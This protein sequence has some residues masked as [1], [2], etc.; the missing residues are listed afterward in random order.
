MKPPATSSFFGKKRRGG[1]ENRGGMGDAILAAHLSKEIRI[2]QQKERGRWRPPVPPPTGRSYFDKRV[3]PF[4]FGA[5]RVFFFSV[6]HYQSSARRVNRSN[7]PI[8]KGNPETKF[9]QAPLPLTREKTEVP[10]L[11]KRIIG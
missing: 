2:C 7:A 11:N 9:R 6:G 4:Q 5:L 10:K 3:P 1:L 8:K